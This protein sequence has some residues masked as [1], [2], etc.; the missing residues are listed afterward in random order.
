MAVPEKGIAQIADEI[1]HTN[2]EDDY[3]RP[4]D[5]YGHLANLWSAYLQRKTG[6]SV[7]I[8]AEDCLQMMILL[9]VNRQA[10]KPKRDNLIDIIGYTICID[11][12]DDGK[13]GSG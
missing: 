13:N 5:N 7:T 4:S 6:L 3:G 11:E 1:M 10:K 2:R 9:K 12:M 8:T